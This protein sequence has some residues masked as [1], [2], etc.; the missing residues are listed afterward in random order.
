MLK[1]LIKEIALTQSIDD[2]EVIDTIYFGGGT[3]SLLNETEL[4]DILNAV[5]NKFEVNPS[6]EVTLEAN[7]DDI[8]PG[9]LNSWLSKGIN[10]LSLGVQ[11]FNEAELKWMNRA[12]NARQSLQSI[13]D[14]LAAGFTNF[15]VD[16]IYGSP[17]LSNGEFEKNVR[18]ITDKNIPHISC[19]ALTV[20]ERTALHHLIEKKKSLP[21]DEARQAEQFELLLKL[22][23]TAGY[24]HYEISNFSK[25]GFRSQHNSS[26]WKGKPYYGFGPSAH[27]YNGKNK[28]SW[29]I[30]SNALY[31][32]S[33]EQNTIPSEEEI[34]TPTQQ[35]NEYIMISLR[36]M[37]GIDLYKIEKDFGFAQK[38]ELSANAASFIKDGLLIA[39]ERF[40]KLSSKGKFL[41]DGIA[42]ELF[43]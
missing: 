19:Y 37:E 38:W 22:T 16:L 25:P 7:P 14:I 34:L 3:P 20:E 28:R 13:D 31:L 12:H 18:I 2:N 27:S 4:G 26:Y 8:G 5:K 6:A 32:Q 23:E 39:D 42:A 1:A 35:L 10:R 21:I 9:L 36:T 24:E 41:A 29:N 15:S 33:L 43:F 30:A 11:S 17:L 40:L